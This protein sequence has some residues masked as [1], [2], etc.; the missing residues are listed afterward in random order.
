MK[1]ICFLSLTPL[2]SP[3]PPPGLSPYISPVPKDPVPPFRPFPRRST[4]FIFRRTLLLFP[5][6]PLLCPVFRLPGR[7]DYPSVPGLWISSLYRSSSHVSAH[8]SNVKEVTHR[9]NLTE[10]MRP[11]TFGKLMQCEILLKYFLLCRESVATL[12]SLSKEI[13]LLAASY[14]DLKFRGY[15]YFAKQGSFANDDSMIMKLEGK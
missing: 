3:I 14:K 2:R 7:C 1:R 10:L 15:T 12:G 13:K 8:L 11:G 4:T 6:L 5:L 9:R